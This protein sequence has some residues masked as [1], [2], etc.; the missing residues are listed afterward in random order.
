[1]SD[2]TSTPLPANHHRDYPGFAGISGAIA[3]LT[4]VPGAG[5]VARLAI[6]LLAVSERDHLVDVGCGPGSAA[7]A[8]ARKGAAVTGIDP[9]PIMLTLARWL[10]RRAGSITWSE[11]T[12]EALPLA[13][14]AATVVWSLKTVHH[15]SA[16]DT[17]L[18]EA[19]RVLVRGG[20]FLVIERHT[21]PGATGLASHGWTDTQAVAFADRC[22]SSGF[23]NVR[24]QH[25]WTGRRHLLTV[26]A[27]N[28]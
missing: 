20:R 3:G 15:W 9:A 23:T 16:L 11:G 5:P 26:Q 6:D 19:H 22:R 4:M 8:A 13:E 18:A 10:T 17:G 25:Q 1:M 28:A 2:P 14:D 24:V 12:A 21:T 7:R 27:E